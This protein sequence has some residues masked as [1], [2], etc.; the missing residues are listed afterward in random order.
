MEK[1]SANK[2][3][4]IL[5]D[6]DGTIGDTETPAMEVAFWELG[7]YFVD[8]CKFLLVFLHMINCLFTSTAINTSRRLYF[9]SSK[10]FLGGVTAALLQEL[11][12]DI[13]ARVQKRRK[14]F[15]R[16]VSSLVWV[17]CRVT[18]VAVS[19]MQPQSLLG[20]GLLERV[21]YKYIQK[22]PEFLN[23]TLVISY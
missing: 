23:M 19:R 8:T 21:S 13:F 18:E 14:K 17:D 3:I 1:A 9:C 7:P 15:T 20:E 6:F 10:Y 11:L 5:F 16:L 12:H 4:S 22:R 2:D